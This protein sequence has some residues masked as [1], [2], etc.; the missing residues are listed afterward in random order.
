MEFQVPIYGKE[1]FKSAIK[2]ASDSSF[3]TTQKYIRVNS[4]KSHSQS[5]HKTN[6][7]T[8]NPFG[9]NNLSI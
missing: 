8:K 2:K 9:Y 5:K 4:P 3:I 1:V 6:R 7:K